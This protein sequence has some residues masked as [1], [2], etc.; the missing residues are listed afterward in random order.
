MLE[1]NP[2]KLL[3]LNNSNHAIKQL[4]SNNQSNKQAM[5]CWIDP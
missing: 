5:R 2:L 1:A 4:K 3:I